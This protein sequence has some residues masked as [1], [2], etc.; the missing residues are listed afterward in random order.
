MKQFIL[1]VVIA[2]L[3]SMHL[4]GQTTPP[5]GTPCM[6][7]LVASSTSFKFK[8]MGHSTNTLVWVSNSTNITQKTIS[9]DWSDY[10]TVSA[11]RI[12]TLVKIYGAIKAIDAGI[13]IINGNNNLASIDVSSNPSLLTLFCTNAKVK[14]LNT[15]GNSELTT[16]VCSN[17]LLTNL[18]VSQNTKLEKLNCAN[19]QLLLLNVANGKNTKL[20][21]FDA[22]GNPSLTCIKVDDEFTPPDTWKK[23][24]AAQWNN[25]S[26][27]PCPNNFQ[28]SFTTTKTV[29]ETIKL[30]I[31]AASADQTD[32]WIDLNNN[33][34]KDDG[35]AV[36][37]A[38]ILSLTEY[39][40]GAQKITL[41]GK[42]S[43]FNC[44]SNQL[45]S[46]DVSENEHLRNLRCN[47]NSLSS[48]DVSKNTNLT[49]LYC[50]SNQ[51]STL[52]I[53]KNIK[54]TD[55]LCSS[56][57]LSTLDIGENIK[58]QYFNCAI[59]LIANLDFS[60]NPDLTRLSCDNN[61]LK[62]LILDQK[63][64]LISLSCEDNQLISLNVANGNNVNFSQLNATNNPN[65]TCIQVDD[66]FTPPD[67][68]EKDA[69][70]QWN[71]D[72]ANPCPNNF[73]ITFTTTKAIGEQITIGV[74]AASADQ[75][76]IWI[77][78]NNNG[79]K[80]DGEAIT[81]FS[82]SMLSK[83]TLGAQSITLYGKVSRLHCSTNNIN[84][85]DIS[86]NKYLTSLQCS[87]NQLTHL[88]VSK[89]INLT[90]LEC[91]YNQLSSLD[92][93][94]NTQLTNI[95]C[96]YNQLNS[97]DVSKNT[98]LTD[99]I[100]SSNQLSTLD[101]GENI[102]L[103]ILECFSN[104]LSSLDL[105]KNIKLIVLTCNLNDLT[106]LDLS[107]NTALAQLTCNDNKLTTLDLSA[108]VAL[109]KLICNDNDLT[110]LDVRN[111]NNGNI[112]S[113]TA[114]NNPDLT[115]IYVD[116]KTAD[117]SAWTKDATATFVNNEADCDALTSIDNIK[118][119]TISIYPNP[120]NGIV[121]FDFSGEPIQIMK[122]V[123]IVGETVFQ[124]ENISETET[125]DI[126]GFANGLYLVILQ[127][128][129]GS[130]S[131]KIIKE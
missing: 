97:L 35:E 94:Q 23:D 121:N 70:A 87:R 104:Q 128:D 98:N 63:T 31:N 51:L 82:T 66:E 6:E 105:S 78:L 72:S 36:S 99:L 25:D 130:N 20:S 18:D 1:L 86:K 4:W 60:Q 44:G 12:P 111:G 93:S 73:Q 5:A 96:G 43:E 101:I 71:N 69:A 79:V 76:D 40:L 81:S 19:N 88:D 125:I 37:S 106:T 24:A 95:S 15:S 85:L 68:W 122:I 48:L 127:T 102:K 32:V 108:N 109:T 54:L 123:T 124:K 30:G 64:K 26:A 90:I 57:Q 38:G 89:N 49:T 52:N 114:N 113:F 118:M 8:L 77:D 61:Q 55:L 92:V 14:T 107:A 39:I 47:D 100:C 22:T 58:L 119:E 129:N 80:D 21:S 65:L 11:G 62:S 16:L 112:T 46:L 110:L 116:D 17:N 120:T 7:F 117:L 34:V 3:S 59:N 50:S 131:F 33:S 74:N 126:S 53:S 42:V 103:T 115:C 41:Y 83:F 2:A 75:A 13:E 27:N 91:Y 67:T 29:G 56:N 10:L 45:S 28:I 9:D 84:S